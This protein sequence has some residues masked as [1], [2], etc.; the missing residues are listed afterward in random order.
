MAMRISPRGIVS[1]ALPWKRALS[2]ALTTVVARLR[3]EVLA[4]LLE[5]VEGGRRLA[6]RDRPLP[7]V[8]GDLLHLLEPLVHDLGI[9]DGLD[10]GPERL[11]GHPA[12]FAAWCCCTSWL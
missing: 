12:S 6:L 7:R 3:E 9:A 1:R 4:G 8:A 10:P 5:A 11:E 2:T